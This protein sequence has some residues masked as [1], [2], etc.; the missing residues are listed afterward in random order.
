MVLENK[1]EL[2]ARSFEIAAAI[3][4]FEDA[5]QESDGIISECSPA[6]R[7]GLTEQRRH[8]VVALEAMERLARVE[9]ERDAAIQDSVVRCCGTCN[10][11]T[12]STYSGRCMVCALCEC[13]PEHLREYHKNH[14]S[15]SLWKWRGAQGEA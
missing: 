12:Q 6:F 7:A 14:Y 4:Y 2:L 10:A 11:C 5:I 13:V 8:F 9:A 3:A 1:Q 15:K